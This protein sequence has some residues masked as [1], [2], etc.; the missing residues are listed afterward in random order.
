MPKKTPPGYIILADSR[1][2]QPWDFPAK[3]SCLGSRVVTLKTGDY[4]LLGYE[5][6]LTIERKGSTSEWSTNVFQDR[7]EAEFERMKEF[8]HAFVIFEFTLQD[9]LDFP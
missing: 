8:T 7:L 2:Q 5:K 6:Y 3:G 1:E 9:I 4:T